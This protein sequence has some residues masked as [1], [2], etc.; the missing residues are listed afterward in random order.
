M[1]AC[2]RATH[3]ENLADV[4]E[5]RDGA[6]AFAGR[7]ETAGFL[8]GRRKHRPQPFAGLRGSFGDVPGLGFG[9]APVLPCALLQGEMGGVGQV[10]DS[11]ARHGH[12]LPKGSQGDSTWSL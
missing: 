12:G 11:D 1:I 9:A 3:Y 7:P 2:R 10:A 6:I 5:A 4:A 8:P